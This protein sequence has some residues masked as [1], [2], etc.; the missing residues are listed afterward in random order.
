M[1]KIASPRTQISHYM[2]LELS[3]IQMSLDIDLNTLYEISQ[4]ICVLKNPM[5]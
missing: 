5:I 2:V 3:T 1:V 4:R